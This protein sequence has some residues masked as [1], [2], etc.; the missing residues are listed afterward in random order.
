[1]NDDIFHEDCLKDFSMDG[2]VHIIKLD[3]YSFSQVNH[4]MVLLQKNDFKIINV[5]M[6]AIGEDMYTFAITYQYIPE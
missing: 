3:N 6:T 4:V 1:M 5:S 2:Y